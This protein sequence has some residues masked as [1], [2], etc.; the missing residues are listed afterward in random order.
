MLPFPGDYLARAVGGAPVLG[1]DA[2]LRERYRGGV[3]S[4]KQE[5]GVAWFQARVAEAHG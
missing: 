2:K 3:L 4:P 5:Q 1:P